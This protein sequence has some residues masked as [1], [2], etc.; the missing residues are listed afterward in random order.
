MNTYLVLSC[1]CDQVILQLPV[2]SD[3]DSLVCFK[4]RQLLLGGIQLIPQTGHLPL[5]AV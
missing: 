4:S 3:C 1:H 2:F 5:A